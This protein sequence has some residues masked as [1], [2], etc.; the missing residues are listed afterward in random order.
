MKSFKHISLL[1]DC[2]RVCWGD[3]PEIRCT[4]FDDEQN[5][6]KISRLKRIVFGE[7]SFTVQRRGH[8]WFHVSARGE[9]EIERGIINNIYL[10]IKEKERRMCFL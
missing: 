7:Y 3:S 10:L 1:S 9:T 5:G 8:V 6:T 4:S 2:T